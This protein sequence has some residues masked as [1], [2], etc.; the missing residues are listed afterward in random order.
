MGSDQKRTILLE[1][2]Y[3]KLIH[4]KLFND[5]IL[6]KNNNDKYIEQVAG[7][8]DEGKLFIACIRDFPRDH[9][10]DLKLPMDATLNKTHRGRTAEAY[11]RSHHGIYT[12]IGHSLGGA[13]ALILNKQYK[14]EGD[15]PY[16]VIQSKTFGSPTVS[17]CFP[18]PNPNRIRWAG[19]PVS[20]LDFSSATV[21]PSFRQRLNNSAHSF[22]GLFIKDA[23]PIH[24]TPKN[25]LTQS[26][27]DSKTEVL[28]Y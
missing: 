27:G 3:G 1:E 23:V 17:G 4:E 5:E 9:I 22:S 21:M 28:T 20:A 16:G 18:G 10:D 19:D 11:Y 8:K 7:F 26:P 2:S 24:D 6:Q 14:Q 12:V 15:N 13:V 25:T